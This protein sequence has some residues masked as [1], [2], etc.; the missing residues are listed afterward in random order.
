MWRR[1]RLVGVALMLVLS[2]AN[3]DVFAQR[4][5]QPL[6]ADRYTDDEWH[7]SVRY[8][9]TP[10][11]ALDYRALK[12]VAERDE[13]ITRFWARRDPTPATPQNEF[14]DEFDRRVAYANAHFANPNDGPHT[15]VDTDRGRIYVLFGAPASVSTYRT[16][17]YE[18]WQ[19]GRLQQFP[20][21]NLQILF[22]IPPIDSCDTSYR[23]LS[24]DPIESSKQGHT[25]GGGVPGPSCDS[26]NR[27]GLHCC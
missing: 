27:G 7:L 5:T 1:S 24:P 18:I 8:I 13:F 16:G 20:A 4:L 15:G 23:V 6:D 25:S 10:Q 14:R 21:K 17:A 22:S 9:M 11:E 12:T 3:H 2:S 19:Y 26:E